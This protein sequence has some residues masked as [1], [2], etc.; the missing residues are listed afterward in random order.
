M[1]V[2]VAYFCL[3]SEFV[4]DKVE[5]TLENLPISFYCILLFLLK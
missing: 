3:M 2:W 4:I 1:G 5:L